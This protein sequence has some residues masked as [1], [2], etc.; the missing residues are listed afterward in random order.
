MPANAPLLSLIVPVKGDTRELSQLRQAQGNQRADVEWIV[1][2]DGRPEGELV[3]VLA[4][5]AS[6]PRISVINCTS[7]GPGIARNVGL[8]AANGMVVAFVDADDLADIDTYIEL[9]RQ[10][11]ASGLKAGVL[12]Y[13]TTRV[14]G[15]GVALEFDVPR[16]G[17]QS[18]WAR[19]A[20]RAGVWRFVFN[21]DF[22]IDVG[23]R[24]PSQV[25]GED[26]IFLLRVLSQADEIWGLAE[27]GYI[28]RL[29]ACGQLTST[30]PPTRDVVRTC[31]E[32]LAALSQPR[33]RSQVRLLESWLG[34]VWMRNRA[35][36]GD[37]LSGPGAM[38][39][40]A[41]ALRGLAWS[42]SWFVR[43]PTSLASLVRGRG[44]RPRAAQLPTWTTS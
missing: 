34:R 31:D 30:T 43:R 44:L 7:E 26:L 17:R 22:L 12:G 18:G 15:P 20:R 19:I 28:Y 42:A 39:A 21:R 36:A 27:L 41:R 1:V 6:T 3:G 16:P 8:D 14:T 37:P 25:Y 32:I 29:H 9:G 24:F 4:G 5:L 11:L 23:V 35:S 2:V 38:R 13:A 33:P 10:M 40:H